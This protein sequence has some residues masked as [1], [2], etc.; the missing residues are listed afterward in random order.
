[1]VG[2]IGNFGNRPYHLGYTAT[3]DTNF[4]WFKFDNALGSFIPGLGVYIRAWGDSADMKN[5]QFS[6]G[7]DANKA[8]YSYVGNTAYKFIPAILNQSFYDTLEG[9]RATSSKYE[10][11]LSKQSN[12]YSMEFYIF[13]RFY[14]LLMAIECYRQRP[15]RFVGFALYK[16]PNRNGK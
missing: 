15:F 13:P 12:T 9:A 7:A 10:R 1:M 8:T 4:T 14:F 11:F 5:I 16:L 6:I 2:A 3:S